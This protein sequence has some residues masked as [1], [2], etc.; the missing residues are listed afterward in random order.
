VRSGRGHLRWNTGL[1]DEN[2]AG[3]FIPLK[4]I[5]AYLIDFFYQALDIFYTTENLGVLPFGGGWAQQPEWIVIV[6]N[7]L[8]VE[9]SL[10]DQ[11]DYEE[12]KKKK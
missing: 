2:G 1:K 7:T 9:Q 3:I 6:L 12:Q 4:D 11:L 5:G 10:C 8:K